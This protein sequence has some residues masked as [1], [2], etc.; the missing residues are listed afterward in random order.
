MRRIVGTQHDFR[1]MKIFCVVLLYI[2]SNS[3]FY[4]TPT[5]SFHASSISAQRLRDSGGLAMVK[6]HTAS[7]RQEESLTSSNV[8]NASAKLTQRNNQSFNVW[9]DTIL[10]IITMISACFAMAMLLLAWEDVTCTFVLPSRHRTSLHTATSSSSSFA[11]STI[12]GLGFGYEQRQLLDHFDAATQELPSYNEVMLRHRLERVPRWTASSS[13]QTDFID[14][15]VATKSSIHTLLDCLQT[16]QQLQVL[17]T[18]NDWDAMR[19]TLR[20]EPLSTQLEAASSQVR[21]SLTPNQHDA[22][23][24]IGFDWGSCGWRHCGALADAQEAL[25]EIDYLL[26]VLEPPEALFCLD[27][28]ERSV[29]DIL[30]SV[31]WKMAIK[32][33]AAAWRNVAEYVPY[34]S[35]D[36]AGAENKLD[37]EYLR[38]LQKFRID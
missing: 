12:H 4:L 10:P 23:A 9:N 38:A 19:T 17:A 28:V 24:T 20:A 33:D 29:R 13:S 5:K 15:D 26:G 2:G 8:Y 31:D 3:A 22:R 11:Q 21:V 27:I 14:N 1:F 32:V 25:D 7:Q 36:M 6:Q 35:R 30:A 37:D 34:Q 16:V 18:N